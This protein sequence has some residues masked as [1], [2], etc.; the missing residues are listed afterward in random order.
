VI[1]DEPTSNLDPN[2]RREVM[3]M[4]REARTAGRTIILSS[5]ILS[6]IEEICDRVVILRAGQIVHAQI[7]ASLRLQHRIHAMLPKGTPVVP[8]SL[9]D[10]V[11]L[12]I[13]DD[14]RFL[15]TTTGDLAPV[16]PWLSSLSLVQLSIEP[17]GLRSVYERFHSATDK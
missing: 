17:T 8:E 6:E 4:I 13:T 15:A 14:S 2:V 11:E 9:R 10:R 5:H 12:T 16:L 7:M 3:L 1:L